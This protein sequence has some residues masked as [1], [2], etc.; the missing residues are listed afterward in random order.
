LTKTRLCAQARSCFGENPFV[1]TNVLIVCT[2]HTPILLLLLI[3]IILGYKNVEK[4]KIDKFAGNRLEVYTIN[5][6][7]EMRKLYTM[8]KVYTMYMVCTMYKVNTMYE[9][10]TIY[11]VYSLYFF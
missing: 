9:I 5:R 1:C 7:N 11:T 10:Y 8:Y 2:R 4:K 3:N 6:V